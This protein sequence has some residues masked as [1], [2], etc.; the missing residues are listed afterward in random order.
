MFERFNRQIGRARCV[1]AHAIDAIAIGACAHAAGQR[2]VIDEVGAGAR[3]RSRQH[4]QMMR[5]AAGERFVRHRL[6]QRVRNHVTQHARGYRAAAD[7]G[8]RHRADDTTG[9]GCYFQ[10]AIVTGVGRHFR[11]EQALRY[12]VDGREQGAIRNVARAFELLA[13]TGKI[14]IDAPVAHRH[15]ET[16]RAALAFGIAVEKIFRDVTTG[17]QP[18]DC[19]AKALFR[20]IKVSGYG[21][22]GVVDAVTLE[23]LQ[24]TFG[25][26][27]VRRE[28]RVQVADALGG[29]AR[30]EQDDVNHVPV[31]FP[32]AHDAH[33]R[34][35]YAFLVDALAHRG[36]RAGHHA[37][38]VG[39]V[40][41][42]GDEGHDL[43]ADEDRRDDIDV[44]QMRAAAVVRIVGDELVTRQDLVE[45]IALENF[46]DRADH[47]TQVYGH[48]LRQRDHLALRV[49]YRG[50]AI[51]AFLDVRRE[52]GAHQGRAHF[53]GSRQQIARDNFRLDRV[54]RFGGFDYFA[55]SRTFRGHDQDAPLI[56]SGSTSMCR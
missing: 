51:G 33:R 15:G 5:P 48:A 52:R 29:R 18:V 55:R 35:A 1:H 13:R 22:G 16:Y 53:L 20:E 32:L 4:V 38:D 7:G 54:H 12:R 56:C 37:A 14:K 46:I 17:R 31:Q 43:L 21:R 45:R 23:Q 24:N 50:R 49:E 3:V 34:N 6:R 39:V 25:A 40:R 30:V 10:C 8:W 2:F 11:V 9:G 26:D 41:D 36:F 27:V 19:R 44:R 42:V 47:R 28:L